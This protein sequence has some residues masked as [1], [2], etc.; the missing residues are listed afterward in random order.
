MKEFKKLMIELYKES[1]INERVLLKK[2]VYKLNL[3]ETQ[4]DNLWNDIVR[5]GGNN[6]FEGM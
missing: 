5:L 6:D 3:S 4:R 1:S 2:I